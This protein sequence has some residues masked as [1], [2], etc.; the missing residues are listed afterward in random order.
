MITTPNTPTLPDTTSLEAA[1]SRLERALQQLEDT[2]AVRAQQHET[3]TRE[4]LERVD[5]V[6]GQIEPLLQAPAKKGASA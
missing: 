1:A 4:L 5:A 2:I 3:H 6:I